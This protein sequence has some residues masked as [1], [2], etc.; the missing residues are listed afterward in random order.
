MKN[1]TDFLGRLGPLSLGVLATLA[2]SLPTAT[3]QAQATDEEQA[4]DPLLEEIVVTGSRIKR[5]STFTSTYPLAVIDASEQVQFGAID[6][7]S[8]LR[9]ATSVA[10]QQVDSSFSGFTVDGGPGAE[11]LALRGLGPERTLVLIDGRRIGAAGNFGAAVFPDLALIPTFLVERAEILLSGASSIYGADA[12]AGVVNIITPKNFEGIQLDVTASFPESNRGEEQL[13]SIQFGSSSDNARF[14]IGGEYFDREGV[15]ALD[16]EFTEGGNRSITID[17][18]GQRVEDP[19]GFFDQTLAFGP[20]CTFAGWTPGEQGG[21][22]TVPNFSCGVD[23]NEEP[24]DNAFAFLDQHIWS[25][26]TRWS[27]FASI[28][29]DLEMLGDSTIYAQ[30]LNSNRKQAAHVGDAQFFPLVPAINT[31]NPFGTD[32]VPVAYDQDLSLIH[33]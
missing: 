9:T 33:I 19:D 32:V 8:L 1:T 27:A 4:D 14:F 20:D 11:T 10:G 21:G 6:A 31:F 16:R 24:W 23:F 17:E 22:S 25:P 7:A 30:V 29:Y 18:N 13:A 15:R 28:E 12:V 3:V 2:L 5:D 26:N